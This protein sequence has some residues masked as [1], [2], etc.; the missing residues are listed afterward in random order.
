MTDKT[1]KK[2]PSTVTETLTPDQAKLLLQ[3]IEIVKQNVFSEV[4]KRLR[5]YL[6]VAA[7]VVTLFGAVSVVGLKTAIKDATVGAFREDS[8]LRQAIRDDAQKKVTEADDLVARIRKV[9]EQVDQDKREGNIILQQSLT[10]LSS[11][12]DQLKTEQRRREIP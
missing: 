8:T 10:D 7:S 3:A 1:D 5:N 12:I 11:L 9:A 2:P 4:V 6:V